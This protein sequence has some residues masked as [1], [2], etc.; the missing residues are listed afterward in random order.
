[1]AKQATINS[2][3]RVR[4]NRRKVRLVAILTL[5]AG[6]GRAGAADEFVV[7][8]AQYRPVSGGSVAGCA[9]VA[10]VNPAPDV[11]GGFA[12]V[13][14][15]PVVTT[16]A[17]TGDSFGDFVMVDA[18]HRYPDACIIVTGLAYIR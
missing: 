9:V 7:L 14:G 10:A 12:A 1:M 8:H 11:S 4:R 6:A 15:V 13:R 18:G 16:H 2:D 3:G 17:L 5:A